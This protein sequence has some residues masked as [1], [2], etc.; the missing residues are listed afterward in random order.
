MK[1]DINRH[2]MPK[3]SI[4]PIFVFHSLFQ[5]MQAHVT[6]D[7]IVLLHYIEICCRFIINI[8]ITNYMDINPMK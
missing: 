6:G 5:K 3:Y 1:T 4:L 7:F 8:C 2:K